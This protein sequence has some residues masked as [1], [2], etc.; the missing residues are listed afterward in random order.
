MNFLML[1]IYRPVAIAMFFLGIMI[2]GGVAWQRMPVELIP[3]L[4]GSEIRINFNR[5]G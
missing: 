5:Q 2:L 4:V 3:R 1:P